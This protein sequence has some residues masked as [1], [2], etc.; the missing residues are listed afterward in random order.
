MIF[1]WLLDMPII[2][3]YLYKKNDRDLP[4]NQ[5]LRTNKDDNEL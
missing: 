5:D 3:A 2:I 1:K 4:S